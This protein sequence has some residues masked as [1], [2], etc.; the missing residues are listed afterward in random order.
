MQWKIHDFLHI[1]SHVQ[2]R[3]AEFRQVLGS[4]SMFSVTLPS[5]E[6]KSTKFDSVPKPVTEEKAVRCPTRGTLYV[7]GIP[8]M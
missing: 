2:S 3:K 1:M 4:E 6:M 5:I 8:Y 7:G